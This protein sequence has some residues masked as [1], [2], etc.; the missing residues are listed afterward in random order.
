MRFYR[1]FNL[2]I[3]AVFFVLAA[4]LPL[5]LADSSGN[6]YMWLEFDKKIKNADGSITQPLFIRYGQFP[7]KKQDIRALSRIE[8]FYTFGEKNK[9]GEDIFYKLKIEEKDGLP[10]VLVNSNRENWCMILVSARRAADGK[11]YEYSAKTTFFLLGKNKY[12]PEVK[13]VPVEIDKGN[14]RFDIK[15][16]RERVKELITY[17]RIRTFPIRVMVAF[18]GRP[19]SNR[20]INI[21]NEFGELQQKK[22]DRSG[23]FIYNLPKNRQDFKMKRRERDFEQDVI[24]SGYSVGNV[25]YLGSCAVLFDFS[26]VNEGQYAHILWQGMAIFIIFVALSLVYALIL[27]KKFKFNL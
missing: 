8:A 21:I 16:Y 6:D 24:F 17:S 18:D 22:T 15:L 10:Y 9:K 3:F 23:V 11:A 26:F 12:A 5:A 7:D 27:R 20:D 2:S 14:K 25:V 13:G 4:G 19:F 1:I